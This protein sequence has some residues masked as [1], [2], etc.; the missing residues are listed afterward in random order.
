MLL[1]AAADVRL[2][3]LRIHIDE[4]N[5]GTLAEDGTLVTMGENRDDGD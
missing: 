4:C 1:V 3:R 2:P 5:Y